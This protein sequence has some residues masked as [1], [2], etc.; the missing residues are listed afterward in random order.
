[1]LK[2]EDLEEIG[3]Y[4]EQ[5]AQQVEDEI[6]RKAGRKV[7]ETTRENAHQKSEELKRDTMRIIQKYSVENA[8]DLR[9]LFDLAVSAALNATEWSPAINEILQRAYLETQGTLI[10]LTQTTADA[11]Q[12]AFLDAMDDAWMSVSNSE[13]SYDTAMIRVCD[14]ISRTTPMV[15]YPTGHKDTLEVAARR[16]IVTGVNQAAARSTIQ[17]CLEDGIDYVEVSA[18]S[19]ARERTKYTKYDY[20]AHAEWQ[21]KI[22]HLE[23]NGGQIVPGH[24]F[25]DPGTGKTYPDFITITGYGQGGGLC[26]WNCRH[27]FHYF[28]P[29]IDTPVYTKENLEEMTAAKYEYRG[30]KLTEYQLSQIQRGMERKVRALKKRK[31]ARDAAG[32]KDRTQDARLREAYRDLR[33]L[34]EQF[35]FMHSYRNRRYV[36]R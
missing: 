26:G 1:M 7:T 22:Y 16:A 13:E 21:G 18:H 29:G 5:I 32:L 15:T 4:A 20:E 2:P 24:S 23:K 10:N 30:Q 14:R 11:S 12:Q 27:T 36:P 25:T 19:G 28:K 31:I 8:D 33:E 17:Y 34:E 35:P 9:R 6:I 3:K